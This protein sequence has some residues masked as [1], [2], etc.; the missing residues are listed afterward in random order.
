MRIKPIKKLFVNGVELTEKS[1]WTKLNKAEFYAWDLFTV[2]AYPAYLKRE[3]QER[4]GPQ[5]IVTV[6][7]NHIKYRKQRLEHPEWFE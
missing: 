4:Y 6:P 7:S 5:D 2:S 1:D 3:V